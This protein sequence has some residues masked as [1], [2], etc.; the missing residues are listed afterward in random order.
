MAPCN[1]APATHN[2]NARQ[3]EGLAE[4]DV[5][6]SLARCGKRRVPTFCREHLITRERADEVSLDAELPPTSSHV[7]SELRARRGIHHQNALHTVRVV[8]SK[9]H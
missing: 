9:L 4:R 6:R 8:L 1:L 7:A 2:F 5:A 3:S